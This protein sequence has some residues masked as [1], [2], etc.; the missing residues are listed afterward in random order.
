MVDNVDDHAVANRVVVG[1]SADKDVTSCLQPLMD[2]I[3]WDAARIHC[4]EVGATL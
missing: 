1:I 2:L 4:V 3:G